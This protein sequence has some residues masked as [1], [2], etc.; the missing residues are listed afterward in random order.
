MFQ[1][2]VLRSG[3]MQ[4]AGLSARTGDTLVTSS[5]MLH[6]LI[7]RNWSIPSSHYVGE[8]AIVHN[9]HKSS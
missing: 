8:R 5:E 6:P 3:I 1:S 4:S 2:L 9:K 7:I